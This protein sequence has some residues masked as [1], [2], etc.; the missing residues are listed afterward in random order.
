MPTIF[1]QYE[2]A[3]LAAAAYVNFSGVDYTDGSE[4][5]DTA[6]RIIL[7]NWKSGEL[8]L[9][10]VA[11]APSLSLTD[12]HGS[13]DGD[14]SDLSAQPHG[15][16][17]VASAAD[18]RV[19]GHGGSDQITLAFAGEIAYGGAGNDIIRNDAGRRD[20]ALQG[21]AEDDTCTQPLKSRRW[22][23][24]EAAAGVANQGTWRRAA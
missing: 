21:V 2:Y 16:T 9:S 10:L 15:A 12:L 17:L 20:D 23:D 14:N 18:Q 13:E 6:A 3:K 5:Q 19:W 11:T 22:Q 8:G 1:Q 4:I 24:G 7:Q